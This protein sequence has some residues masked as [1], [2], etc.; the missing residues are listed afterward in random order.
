MPLEA[1]LHIR[2]SAPPEVL[3]VT[4][5]IAGILGF[6]EAALLSGAIRLEARIHP[7]DA[8]I[9]EQL[10]ATTPTTNEQTAN[11]RVRHNDGRIR[12][13]KA[14][15]RRPPAPEGSDLVLELLLQE[16]KSLERTL[17]DAA[18]TLS[19]RAM[20]ENT[21]DFIYF[22][23]RN[24]V[25]TGASQTLVT[26]C[27]PAEHWTDL[28]GQTDY[29]IFPEAYADRYYAL[30]KRVF[31]GEEIAREIQ[32]TL[33]RNGKKGWVD[34]RKYPI[35]D[36]AGNIIG[37]FGVARDITEQVCMEQALKESEERFRVLSDASFGGIIIHDQ[38]RILE[39]NRGLSAF[40]GFTYSEL[41]GKDGLELIA[42]ESRDTVVNNIRS[43]YERGYQVTG[44]RKD[45]SRY[46]LAIR[47]K[48]THYQG[49]EVRVI[50]FRD[51]SELKRGEEQ[52]RNSEEQLR[53]V[54][55]GADLGFWDWNIV[56]GE[57]H[58][59]E[60]WATMLGY[61]YEEIRDTTQ[62]WTDFIHPDDRDKAWQSINAV[63]QGKAKAHKAEY[64]MLH[65][66]G[67]IRWILDQANVIQ[68]DADGNPTRMSGT[69]TDITERKA[70]E[71]E[72]ERHRHHLETLVEERTA[73]LSVAKELA[74]S[75]NRAKS[76]FLTNMSHEL[77]TPM[78]AIMGMTNLALRQATESRLKDQLTK[79]DVASRHLLS[80]IND[81]LDI[82]KIEAERLLLESVDFKIG[83]VLENLKSLIAD[84]AAE[85]NLRLIFDVP[86]ELA[87]LPLLG[88][89][90]RLGQILLNYAG[91]ALKF[92]EHGTITIRARA[93]ENH[94]E[95]IV[96]CCE[97]IDTGVGIAPES[98]SRLFT[99]FEQADG[100]MTRKY[101]G[102]GL[103]LAI[104]KRLAKLM[105]GEVGLESREG[106]GSRFWFTAHLFKQSR[107]DEVPANGNDTGA[108][109][110]T[111]LLNRYAGTRIL[112]AEDEPINQEVSLSLLEDAG[113]SVD[114]AED[115]LR[116]V[117]LAKQ[118]RYALILMDMQMPSLNGL[119]ATRAI[120][121][122]PECDTLPII[123]MTA[124]AF[125]EDRQ[126]CL[127]AGMNDHIGK[128]VSPAKLYETLLKWLNRPTAPS[129]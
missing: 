2:L 54:L 8:D 90:L 113:L 76:Q 66:D 50:E 48:N 95:A 11:L 18:A 129:P 80:V 104:N 3:K 43:G 111:R 51:I 29:D 93:I 21:N 65:K 123:A 122:L 63:L 71:L 12:C 62:Q 109:A 83:E 5:G 16:A 6:S 102:T 107:S 85:K 73:A 98:Q 27:E 110:E 36:D 118:N 35:R 92:T 69:H 33:S 100:S 87:Q 79:I 114:L 61:S 30:E 128:P 97:V 10:F 99:A 82:S 49:R 19:F 124:N 116:A 77:R 81:I 14:T 46:P 58:R 26:L 117:E 67:S 34:N 101:G 23:D 24:H 25:M 39:C 74:E 53:F 127:D 112:L 84:K 91:N 75:A 126:R 31:A 52:L 86:P 32:E 72:L 105:G 121:G 9:A 94:A 57:V 38:G 7:H 88:D 64:R 70:T 40:T 41:I 22:K 78:N 28:I 119:D 47:G 103:G 20:M 108:T 59:N 96:L 115:G 42:P 45:G 106:H 13:V 68:R 55:E 4:A 17:D 1:E 125:D 37:L 120:R 89:P 44:L 60:R 15:Y 56:T